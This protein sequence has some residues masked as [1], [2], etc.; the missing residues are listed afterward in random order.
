MFFTE[1][2]AENIA[3]RIA[4]C[5]AIFAR[6]KSTVAAEI[7]DDLQTRAVEQF[8]FGWEE[9]EAWEIAGYKAA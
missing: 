3:A 8:G 4:E 6:T 9:V 7:M 1:T 5:A 2:T